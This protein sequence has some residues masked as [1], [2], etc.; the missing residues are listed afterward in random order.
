[1]GNPEFIA[2][3]GR[4]RLVKTFLVRRMFN[5]KFVFDLVGLANAGIKAGS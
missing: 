1:L 3:Y 2:L 4:R 5:D